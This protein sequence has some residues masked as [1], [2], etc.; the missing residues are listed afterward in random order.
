MVGLVA[1]VLVVA[2]STQSAAAITQSQENFVYITGEVRKPG[3]YQ[4]V[5]SMTVVQLVALA[6]GLLPSADKGQLV[7][8]DDTL[9]DKEGNPQTRLVS[10]SDILKGRD[11]G[12][13]NL[14]LR[15]GDVVIVRNA[16]Q[17]R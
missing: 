11:L 14:K 12:K 17:P 13:N 6:G 16:A 10:Y 3:K 1:R 4:L 9:K 5:G 2:L 8:V 7:I 15:R